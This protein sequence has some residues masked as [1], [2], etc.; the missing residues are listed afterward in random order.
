MGVPC[1]VLTPHAR[2]VY[3]WSDKIMAGMITIV[4]RELGALVMEERQRHHTDELRM[5]AL[6]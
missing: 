2:Q 3:F 6:D 1:F 4:K 5:A